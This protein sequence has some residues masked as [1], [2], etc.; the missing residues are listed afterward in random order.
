[1]DPRLHSRLESDHRA[2]GLGE[3]LSELDF[4][5]RDLMRD[6]CDSGNDLT[7]QQAQ[8]E[9]VR[10]VKNDRFGRLQAKS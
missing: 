8:R 1:V 3:A 2:P 10:V 4:K 7:G 6:R 9:L 5:R